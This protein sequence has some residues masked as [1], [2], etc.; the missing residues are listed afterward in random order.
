MAWLFGSIFLVVVW[1][2]VA[3]PDAQITA[4]A[5]LDARQQSD[6]SALGWLSTSGAST[7]KHHDTTTR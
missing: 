3:T 2:V 7:C 6:P 5:K 1:S 4:I